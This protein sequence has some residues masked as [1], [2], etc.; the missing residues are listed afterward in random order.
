MPT[1]SLARWCTRSRY[2][3]G[4]TEI[5][6]ARTPTASSAS[7]VSSRCFSQVT[8][9][10]APSSAAGAKAAVVATCTR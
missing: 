2:A 8:T 3:S 5:F 7:R 6:G 1:S 4:S 9:E 10:T